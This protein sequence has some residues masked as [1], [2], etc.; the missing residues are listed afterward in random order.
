MSLRLSNLTVAALAITATIAFY[1]A[2]ATTFYVA[3]DGNDENSGASPESAFL[4]LAKAV[5]VATNGTEA[6]EVLIAPGEYPQT[7]AIRV[8]SPLTIRGTGTAA[9]NVVLKNTTSGQHVITIAH[10]DAELALVTLTRGSAT[11]GPACLGI[12]AGLVRDCWV[13]GCVYNVAREKTGGTVFMSGGRLTRS[14]VK[15]NS[16]TSASWEETFSAGVYATAGVVENCLIMGNSSTSRNEKKIET[17][18]L[19]MAGTAQAVNCTVIGNSAKWK[20]NDTRVPMTTHVGANAKIVNCVIF[21]NACDKPNYAVWAGTAANYI[22]C[23]SEVA[24]NSTCLDIID[25]AF[26]DP[27]N[28]D[29]TPVYASPLRDAGSNTLYTA[30]ATS[31]TDIKGDTRIL[32]GSIDIGAYEY[33]PGTG[34]VVDFSYTVNRRLLPA[35]VTFT[36]LPENVSGEVVYKWDFDS[37][38][39][40]DRET[41]DATITA[42]LAAAK[43][44]DV[45]LKAVSGLETATAIK[46]RA[47]STIQKDI[48]VSRAGTASYPYA[49]PVTA[50]VTISEALETAEDGCVIHVLPGTYSQNM[51]LVLAKAVTIVSTTTNAADV[52]LRNTASNQRIVEVGDEGA[53][54]AGVTLTNGKGS[55]RGAALTLTAGLV[56]DCVITN[57]NIGGAKGQSSGTVWMS[58]GRLMRCWI[59]DNSNGGNTGWNADCAAGV[60]AT[61]GVI[62]S[63]LVATNRVHYYGDSYTTALG[64]K[65]TGSAKAINCTIAN[66][67]CANPNATNAGKPSALA[68]TTYAS[69][70]ARF[71]NCVIWGNQ[72]K[73]D[74]EQNYVWHGTAAS[75]VNCYSELTINETSP[76][77]TDPG[78]SDVASDDYSLTTTSPLVNKG[79]DYADV[80]GISEFDIAG[81]PRKFGKGV[82]I[83]CYE[84]Q[85]S[86]GFYIFVR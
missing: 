45:T 83:G 80:G 79:A 47:F 43:I 49:T 55:P 2:N 19:S 32:H 78:F 63:C 85:K 24:I 21:G 62:D 68:M 29:Y 84:C 81:N 52:I 10:A 17:S 50:A 13:T 11:I 57:N 60:N 65:L 15:G 8:E 30:A 33:V 70:N 12:E 82:D 61:G 39:T 40:I 16:A 25:P 14:V 67:V 5:E 27:D 6:A 56:R 1:S 76:A 58:G 7:A 38:G 75:Y 28:G 3:T 72:T 51:P 37:D 35:S 48:F 66:N 20:D 26:I 9:T 34:L 31:A 22:N 53:E 41:T 18:A 42:E 77:I 23:A 4:T 44:Y 46:Y 36:A 74:D 86:P 73:E 59:A 69:S 54:L 64:I 71:V